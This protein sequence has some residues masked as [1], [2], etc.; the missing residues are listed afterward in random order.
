MSGGIRPAE[1]PDAAAIRAVHLAA[2]PTAT[3]ADLVAALD[4]DGDT[5]VSLVGETQGEIVG[6][7]LLSRM[8]VTGGGRDRRAVALAPV[9][10]RPD[11]QG[12]GVGRRLIE[13][14]LAIARATGE[15]LVFVLGE[16]AY[17]GRFGFSAEAAAPF[18]SPYAGPYFMALALK[19]GPALHEKGE[20]AYAPAF[21]GL[22]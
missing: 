14:A 18:A 13:G 2:F 8:R 5:V 6:H 10:V 16:P 19:E 7:A 15:E 3:E 12:A 20:A 1:P 4:R 11:F 17:Y 22:A 9:G 21:A